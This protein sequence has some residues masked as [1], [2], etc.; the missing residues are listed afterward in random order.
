MTMWAGAV[1][2]SVAF[3]ACSMTRSCVIRYCTGAQA[4]RTTWREGLRSG[5]SQTTS[6]RQ[7]IEIKNQLKLPELDI[8]YLVRNTVNSRK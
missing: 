6:T 2:G 4:H 8:I 3:K 5:V 7:G 1:L